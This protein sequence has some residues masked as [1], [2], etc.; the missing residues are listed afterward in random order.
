MVHNDCGVGAIVGNG[1]HRIT[2]YPGFFTARS[3]EDHFIPVELYKR[4][5]DAL[6]NVKSLTYKMYTKQ[7]L[8]ENYCNLGIQNLF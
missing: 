1:K 5:I 6:T 4:V 2:D 3:N 7:D 8:A